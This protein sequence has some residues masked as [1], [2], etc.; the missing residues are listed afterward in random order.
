MIN[1]LFALWIATMPLV[2]SFFDLIGINK[3]LIGINFDI[4]MQIVFVG[5]FYL[6]YQLFKTVFTFNF[7]ELKNS[8][9][10]CFK[11]KYT[12]ILLSIILLI[13]ISTLING[14]HAYT[15]FY[16]GIIVIFHCVYNLDK[17]QLKKFINV[18]IF[19]TAITCTMGLLDPF[20]NFMPGFT[21]ELSFPLS[22]QYLNPNYVGYLVAMCLAIVILKLFY[23]KDIK[24]YIL[25]GLIFGIYSLYI[26][27]NASFVPITG[28]FFILVVL[29]V[30]F[31]IKN[32]KFPFK[33]L[34]LFLIYAS[35]AFI[36]E[37]IP[38]INSY[39][40]CGFNYYLEFIAVFDNIFG[41]DILSI[42][43]IERIAGADGWDRDNLALQTLIKLSPFNGNIVHF[44][45]GYGALGI[46][47]IAPHNVY[48][49]LWFDYGI[50]A[51]LLLL[52][53]Q[54]CYFIKFFKSEKTD[55]LIILSTTL[56]IMMVMGLFG[57]ITSY[58]IWL[59]VG[60]MAGGYKIMNNQKHKGIINNQ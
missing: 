38:N 40:T 24:N 22:N 10:K 6:L 31:W 9:S 12:Y 58:W 7:L 28:V 54:I 51:M 21:G 49:C 50:F 60:A 34:Y 15:L 35:F 14:F 39:R 47:G 43:N 41:T 57:G 55:M 42:F 20:G 3:Q 19:V 44:F 56:L 48:L 1:F 37:L 5:I 53:L 26:F 13:F 29:I 18:S 32:K 33:L 25:Y 4:P 30:F 52:V 59:Q 46:V 2:H 16:I 8:L 11:K 23:A 36:V 45:F 17:F 27:M